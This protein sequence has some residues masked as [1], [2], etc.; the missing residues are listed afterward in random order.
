MFDRLVRKIGRQIVAR[1]AHKREYLRM[2]EKQIRRT[3]ICLTAHETVEILEPQTGGPLIE[4]A[5]STIGVDRRV[6][7]LAEPRRSKTIVPQ[8]GTDGGILRPD[9]RIVARISRRQFSAH[10]R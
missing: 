2:I 6:V 10:A 4:W 9:D 1:L 8:N 5:G 7:I 3:M